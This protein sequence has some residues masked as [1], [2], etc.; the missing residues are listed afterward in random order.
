MRCARPASAQRRRRRQAPVDQARETVFRAGDTSNG[1]ACRRA[2]RDKRSAGEQRAAAPGRRG[3]RAVRYPPDRRCRSD[4]GRAASSDSLVDKLALLVRAD[5]A[6]R[7]TMTL[8]PGEEAVAHSLAQ[9]VTKPGGG[10]A[11]APPADAPVPTRTRARRSPA[12]S[13]GSDAARG[14]LMTMPT[15]RG[16][17]DRSCSCSSLS[18]ASPGWRRRRT[19]SSSRPRASPS[20]TGS[21]VV[22]IPNHRAPIV[23]QMVWYKVGAADEVGGKSGIAHFLEHLMFRGTKEVPPGAF[24]RIVAQ[25]GG[26]RERL[27]HA[28]LHRL[29][30]ER[31]RRP[32]RAG[33]EARSRA[34]GQSRHQRRGGD[35]RARGHHRRAPHA[36]STTAPRRCSTSS[37]MPR[38]IFI[39]PTAIPTIGWENEMRGLTAAGCAGILQHLV[40]AQQRHAGRR[41]RRHGRKGEGAGREIL[42]PDPV[43]AGAG[44]RSA[45]RSRPRSRRRGSA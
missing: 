39:I 38:S 28:R 2:E 11:A 40:R 10:P 1:Q 18:S 25:N 24:S 27:H 16:D 34:H 26:R 17:R 35:A 4:R 9:S 42:R 21:Q 5:N 37:S 41:R 36:A 20:P 45:S 32:A 12:G 7:P 6:G 43:A 33:D 3:R 14:G 44:A 23:T 15:L 13:A 22:V 8:N 29:F 30:P 31:R 19:P